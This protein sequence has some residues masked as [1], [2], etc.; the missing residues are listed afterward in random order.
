MRRCTAAQPALAWVLAQGKDAVPISGTERR[1]Y[2][3]DNA[4]ALQVEVSAG[5]L[6]R[7]DAVAPRGV[8][9]GERYPPQALRACGRSI[10][11]RLIT[12]PGRSR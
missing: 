11:K 3:E 5:D 1:R 8:A 2:P 4:G 12:R 9:A 10:A 7:I 6:A